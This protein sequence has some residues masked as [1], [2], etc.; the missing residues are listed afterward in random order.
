MQTSSTENSWRLIHDGASVIDLFQ[1]SGV[2]ETLHTLF[3][4]ATKVECVAEIRRL[5]LEYTDDT[6]QDTLLTSDF[7]QR[8]TP[9]ERITI[10]SKAKEDPYLDDFVFMVQT[11]Q[12]VIVTNP[13]TLAGMGYLVQ[14][15]CITE[16]RRLEILYG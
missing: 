5:G 14:T 15:E 9:R 12:T 13:V 1:S 8:F 3:E 4:A 10:R 16:Q 7:L 11:A 2:T 6:A